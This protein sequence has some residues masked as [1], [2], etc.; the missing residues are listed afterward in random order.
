MDVSIKYGF[1]LIIAFCLHFILSRFS[2]IGVVF[3]V[4]S[5][6][7]FVFLF[8]YNQPTSF[9]ED[10]GTAKGFLSNTPPAPHQKKERLAIPKTN[11]NK[12][13]VNHWNLLHVTQC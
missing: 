3:V 8:G 2:G 5:F 13:F 10:S 12:Y 6:S 1:L 11:L 7:D 9:I 4:G